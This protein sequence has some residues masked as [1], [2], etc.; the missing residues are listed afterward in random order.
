MRSNKNNPGAKPGNQNAA[1]PDTEKL[2]STIVA[3]CKPG[4][5]AAWVKAAQANGVKLT[6][7]IVSA[8]NEKADNQAR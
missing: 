2:S 6:E 8:L 5:K 7:W 1:K 4:D 3:R